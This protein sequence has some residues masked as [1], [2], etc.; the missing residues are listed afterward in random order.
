MSATQKNIILNAADQIYS[1]YREWS[2]CPISPK[3]M[4]NIPTHLYGIKESMWCQPRVTEY[5]SHGLHVVLPQSSISLE[6]TTPPKTE[7]NSH[8]DRLH[9]IPPICPTR[10][11]QWHFHSMPRCIQATVSVGTS[12]HFPWEGPH[13]WLNG[14]RQICQT[15]HTPKH[16]LLRLQIVL[17]VEY[18][19]AVVS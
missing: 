1:S 14:Q 19:P 6:L 12:F 16:I 11:S 4:P 7:I 2:L 3:H 15:H 18:S 5:Q 9:L 8:L 13:S 17:T 10:Y